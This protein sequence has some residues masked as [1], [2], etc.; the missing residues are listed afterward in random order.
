[1]RA[2][3]SLLAVSAAADAAMF[4]GKA[5]R[6]LREFAR[7]RD[8]LAPLVAEPRPLA[9]RIGAVL[10]ASGLRDALEREGTAEAEGRLE[11]LDELCVA[12]EEFEAREG[13]GLLSAFLDSVV[14]LADVDELAEP[15]AA[16]TLM[17][18]HAAKGLEFPVVF[19]TGL[20]EGVFPHARS[21]SDRESLEEER[22]LAYVGLTRAKR[23]LFLSYATRR[24]VG[25]Y[26]GMLEPSRFL[27]EM[28][29]DALVGIGG[30]TWRVSARAAAVPPAPGEEVGDDYPLQVG[31]RVRH[32]RWGEGLLTGIEKDGADFLVTVNFAAAGKRRLALSHAPLEEV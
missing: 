19:L 8:R 25:G 14:L 5:A 24:R 32:A 13:N 20:E 21:L 22:R 18:L 17:T 2:G 29:E 31:A 16:V 11:N 12:A 9:E 30:G 26:G 6:A 27:L 10:D 4:G 1:A 28:P 15:R 7:L 3:A 23:R